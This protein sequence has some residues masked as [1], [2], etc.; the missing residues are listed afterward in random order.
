MPGGR[1]ELKSVMLKTIDSSLMNLPEDLNRGGKA[2]LLKVLKSTSRASLGNSPIIK[3][4]FSPEF[5]THKIL[6]EEGTTKPSVQRAENLAADHLQ[7]WKIPHK[8]IRC[9]YPMVLP[10]LPNYHARKFVIKADH[11][12]KTL[13]FWQEALDILKASTVDLIWG[14]TM[15]PELHS[16]IKSSDSGFF[17]SP[18]LKGAM[19]LSYRG[20]ICQRQEIT[21]LWVSRYILVAVDYL[22]KWVEA[23]VLPTNDA[24]VVCKF[25]K[26]LFSRF[27]APRAIIKNSWEKNRAPGRNKFDFALWA[28]RHAY[29]TPSGCTHIKLGVRE[30]CHYERVRAPGLLG[31]QAY[32]LMFKTAGDPQI[33]FN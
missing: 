10:I 25:L 32:N 24:R 2:A 27:G 33:S 18:H 1:K 19:T 30:A 17:G 26:S 14:N 20:D 13:C 5:C 11:V 4:V 31:P 22:S 6:M 9:Y 23:K 29:K 28:F 7:D 12:I 8:K 3:R 15:V 21:Q 16:K